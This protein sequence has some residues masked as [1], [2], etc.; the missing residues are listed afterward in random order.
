MIV[1]KWLLCLALYITQQCVIWGMDN[2]YDDD[3]D[4]TF[5]F[6]SNPTMKIINE[7]GSAIEIFWVSEKRNLEPMIDQPLESG[8][9]VTVSSLA[10]LKYGYI[11]CN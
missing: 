3:E 5:G 8:S 1:I 7:V 11:V 2:V 9:D 4:D 10:K 6:P